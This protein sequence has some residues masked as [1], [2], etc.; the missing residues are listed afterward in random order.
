MATLSV[1]ATAGNSTKTHIRAGR[2]EFLIDEPPFFGGED[3][4]PSPVEMLLASL[5]GAI[6]AIGQY[7]A[8]ELGMTIRRL[9]IAV[10]GDCD[11][12]RFFG[13]SMEGRAGF[14][15]VRVK[16]TLDTDA[17]PETAAKWEEQVRLRCPVLDNLTAP[18]PVS[19]ETVRVSH[20]SN[21][22]NEN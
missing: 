19:L 10:D 2:H 9:D 3:A 8:G 16:L 7:V 4:A 12:A 15:D 22:D 5:A 17:D 18:A 21:P 11:A 1:R 6:N 13:K 20:S 14:Q